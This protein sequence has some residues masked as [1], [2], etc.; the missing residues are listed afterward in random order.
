MP[1]A[2]RESPS[3][4]QALQILAKLVEEGVASPAIVT[5]ARQITMGCPKGDDECELQAIYEAVKYGTSKVAALA[6]GLRY[7]SDPISP[8]WFQGAER[9]LKQCAD[10]ACAADCDEHAVLVASL[11]GAI[12]FS[13]GLRAWGHPDG[14]G[15]YEHVYACAALP[16]HDPPDD[17]RE[18]VALDTTVDSAYVGWDPPKGFWGTVKAVYSAD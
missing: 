14:K 11:A 10:G 15:E 6:K 12:G 16:K 8:D 1:F 17:P 7:V 2:L 4:E 18:W 13:V 9:T 3:Q 5:C